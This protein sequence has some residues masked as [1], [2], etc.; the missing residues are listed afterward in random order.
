MVQKC[1]Q[2]ASHTDTG[3]HGHPGKVG[4]AWA[5]E[6]ARPMSRVAPGACPS[7]KELDGGWPWA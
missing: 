7:E 5:V 2:G 1:H 3:S 4:R 6:P